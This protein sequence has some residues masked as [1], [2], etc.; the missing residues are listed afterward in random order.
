MEKQIS[1][2][3]VQKS[4]L[5]FQ[6]IGPDCEDNCCYDWNIPVDKKHYKLYKK[7]KDPAL[8]SILQTMIKRNKKPESEQAYAYIKHSSSGKCPLLNASNLCTLHLKYGT[9]ML[10]NTCKQYPR[11][12]MEINDVYWEL[13]DLSCPE[14]ARLTLLP[15][16]K[17]EFLKK[18]VHNKKYRI[19]ATLMM[20]DAV[21]KKRHHMIQQITITIL[22]NQ[23]YT[24]SERLWFLGILLE[25]LNTVDLNNLE[26]LEGEISNIYRRLDVNGVRHN[27]EEWSLQ[28]KISV[29]PHYIEELFNGCMIA[30]MRMEQYFDE[31]KQGIMLEKGEVH[32]E[33]YKEIQDLYYKRNF[34]KYSHI[35]ENYAINH[36][37]ASIFP[38]SSTQLVDLFALLVI[39]L[40]ILQFLLVGIAGYHKNLDTVHVIN[41]LQKYNKYFNHNSN[42]N[43]FLVLCLQDCRKRIPC[44]KDFLSVMI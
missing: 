16:N 38:G 30:D 40:A 23:K 33:T 5:N 44:F 15:K 6:C 28:S 26:I 34:Q 13:G 39:E 2:I 41:L 7:L 3:H 14:I 36:I 19:D 20:N 42:Y 8:K 35:F 24:L 18:S 27:F 10:C 32:I 1:T 21:E 11:K 9:D 43:P 4:L 22:Q 17:I 31:Y 37:L 29:L 12:I 25:E